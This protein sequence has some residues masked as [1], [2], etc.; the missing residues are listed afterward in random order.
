MLGSSAAV[1]NSA[2]EGR[3]MNYLPCGLSG[4][5]G[6]RQPNICGCNLAIK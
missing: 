3:K 5:I 6:R 1:S 2:W 4:C